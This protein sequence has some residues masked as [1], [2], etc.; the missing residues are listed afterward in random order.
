MYLIPIVLLVV[1]IVV[2]ASANSMRK[3]GSMS[4]SAYSTLVSTLSILV[5]VA[6]L[7]LLFMRLRG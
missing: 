2:V 6:A 1:L 5:T 4:D 7:V 3:K